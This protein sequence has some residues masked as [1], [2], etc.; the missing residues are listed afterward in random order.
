[1]P[2]CAAAVSLSKR[3]WTWKMR[4]A[5]SSPTRCRS[6]VESTRSVNRSVTGVLMSP[7]SP[8]LGPCPRLIHLGQ[9]RREADRR[10]ERPFS[11]KAY[12]TRPSRTLAEFLLRNNA[13]RA[14]ALQSNVHGHDQSMSSEHPPLGAGSSPS[15]VG[16]RT[17]PVQPQDEETTKEML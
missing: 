9:T 15:S 12:G 6:S 11:A 4:C 17:A 3:W 13:G 5:R 1:W 8:P 10:D 16:S 7:L 2:P 14:I